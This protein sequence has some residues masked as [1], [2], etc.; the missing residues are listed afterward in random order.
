MDMHIERT[1]ANVGLGFNTRRLNYG[2]H[3]YAEVSVYL[4]RRVVHLSIKTKGSA[5][6]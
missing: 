3:G 2:T 6:R 1:T 5:A 4:W